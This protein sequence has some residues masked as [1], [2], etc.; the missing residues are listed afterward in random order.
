M[1]SLALA[2]LLFATTATAAEFRVGTWNV[3]WFFDHDPMDD[4]STIGH[5]FAAPSEEEYLARVA[6]IASGIA[7]MNPDVMALQE[8]ENEKVVQDVADELETTHS[9]SYNVAFVQGGDTHTGQ[10]VAF[11]V[12]DGLNID[13]SR[14]PFTFSGDTSF[15][16]LSKHLA[17][18][19]EV[20]G[21]PVT[22]VTIHLITNLTDR[23]RQAKSLHAWV[24]SLAAGNLI[25]LGDFNTGL[26][27]TATSTPATSEMGIISGLD[28]ATTADDLADVHQFLPVDQRAT[29]VSNKAFDRVLLSQS[30]NDSAGLRF[31]SLTRHRDLA[32]KDAEDQGGGVDYDLDDDEQDV[33]DHFPLLAVFDTDG[34]PTPLAAGPSILDRIERLQSTLSQMQEELEQLIQEIQG[35][36]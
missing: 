25:V 23:K 13:A 7:A 2:A 17:L 33:S 21:E 15:K 16:N 30:L 32:I 24:A 29:H 34:A 10:D 14:F 4:G 22:I 27:P 20:E 8:I 31:L 12:K 18:T 9:L 19:I 6:D 28:T 1:R 36:N 3:E 26:S 35:S 11:L 5:Q